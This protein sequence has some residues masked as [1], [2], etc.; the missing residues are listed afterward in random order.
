[1]ENTYTSNT[2]TVCSKPIL[3]HSLAE[4]RFSLNFLSF[5]ETSDF[6]IA[7]IFISKHSELLHIH[8]PKLSL[9]F[10]TKEKNLKYILQKSLILFNSI[11]YERSHST[12]KS[13][14][15]WNRTSKFFYQLST[16]AS[17]SSHLDDFIHQCFKID[18]L[19][20]FHSFHILIHEK[21][22]LK[23]SHLEYESINKRHHPILLN[24]FSELYNAIKKSKNRSFGQESLK[25]AHFNIIG[26][27]IGHEFSLTQFNIIILLSKNDFLPQ[28]EDDISFFNSVIPALEY[29]INLFLSVSYHQR[30]IRT[31]EKA[32]NFLP[33]ADY[34]TKQIPPSILKQYALNNFKSESDYTIDIKHRERVSL[35][36]EL[37]NT[38]RHELSNP[39]FGLR[40]S[41]ELLL[42]EDFGEDDLFLIQEMHKAVDRCHKI[43]E[44]FSHLY[45]D[46]DQV[47]PINII[48]LLNE[49]FILTKSESKSISRNIYLNDEAIEISQSDKQLYLKTNKTWMAQVFFNLII[50]SA[51][52]LNDSK[53]SS[54][55]ISVSFNLGS[56]RDLL[57]VHFKDNGPGLPKDNKEK[58]LEPFFTTKSNGTGLG[59]SIASSLLTK[60]GGS[61]EILDSDN[62]AHF[63]LS[64]PYEN[65]NH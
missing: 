23:V 19:K 56:T 42:L 41:T 22:T 45:N 28:Q 12:V 18:F 50:N 63:L 21:G 61:I 1:M 48:Q 35:L 37:L 33:L 43:L 44:N 51:Q 54:P 49:I 10:N 46:K 9:N 25:A 20:D 31:V 4:T 58:I 8:I 6:T 24:D 7:D 2:T 32:L 11:P 65:T 17:K 14:S 29:K 5:Q 59:L 52:A 55:L 16:I 38:L 57:Q 3:I 27:C 30:Y 62:G 47:E 39:L 26:T 60:M 40:L 53:V 34:K 15:N 13:I 36:G 64:L